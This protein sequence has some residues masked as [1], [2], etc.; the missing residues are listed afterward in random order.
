MP[1]RDNSAYS[2]DLHLPPLLKTSDE[3][4]IIRF[5]GEVFLDYRWGTVPGAGD[6]VWL[7]W[8]IMAGVLGLSGA[9]GGGSGGGV[10]GIGAWEGQ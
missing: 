6:P 2:P 5:T 7:E 1:D 4:W 3:V 10:R 9:G 8:G